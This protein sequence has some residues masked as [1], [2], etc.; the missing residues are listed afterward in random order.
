MPV[1]A[2]MACALAVHPAAAGCKLESGPEAKVA[3]VL[4]GETVLLQSGR[5]VRLIG[6]LAPAA[7]H[8]WKQTEPWPPAAAAKTALAALLG[9]SAVEL[10]FAGRRQDRRGRYLAH[11]YLARGDER[12]WVQAYLIERGLARAYSFLDNRACLRRLQAFEAAARAQRLGLWRRRYYQV[13]PAAEPRTLLRRMH[14]FQIVEGRVADVGRTRGWTF[15]NFSDDWKRDFT[16]A[17]AARDR[18]RFENSDVTLAELAG[19]RVRVRGWIES[20][21]GPVI[22]ATHPEQIE[23]LDQAAPDTPPGDEKSPAPE[24]P[25]SVNL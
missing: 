18:R 11:L 16:V 8:W 7:P 6:A 20:W 13:V 25:G 10:K 2:V 5:T 15:L 3:R 12:I 9:Q 1:A 4:D 19:K 23:L 14:S 22:K 21:N 17:V 24:A